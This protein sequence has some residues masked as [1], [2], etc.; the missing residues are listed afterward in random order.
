M[1][2]TKGMMASR[3]PTR[4]ARKPPGLFA[5]NV[6]QK[7]VQNMHPQ[8]NANILGG[9][10]RGGRILGQYPSSLGTDHE[11]SAG[12]GRIIPTT[13]WDAVWHSLAQWFGVPDSSMEYVLP[14]VR[15][16]EGCE[17]T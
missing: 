3:D 16:F 1:G 13:S 15:N 11:L 6:Q 5:H 17:G 8:Q 4:N 10:V 9:A 2:T 12:R 14:N 7:V